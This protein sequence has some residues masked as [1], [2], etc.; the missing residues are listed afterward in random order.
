LA[1]SVAVLALCAGTSACAGAH[2]ATGAT[3]NRRIDGVR[4][5]GR[6]VSPHSY[7]WFTRAELHFVRGEYAAAVDAYRQA[8]VGPT[9]DSLVV[10]RLAVALDRDGRREEALDLLEEALGDNPESEA[11][12]MARA[13]IAVRHDQPDRAI[14]AFERAEKAAPLST[15]PPLGLA[16]FLRKRDATE[17]AVAVLERFERRAAREGVD[18][19]R[20]RLAL[21]IDRGDALAAA[22]AARSLL[23]IEPES[24]A[25][26]RRAAR[27]AFESG[28]AALA[29]RLVENLPRRSGDNPLLLQLLLRTGRVAAV[30]QLLAF[31]DAESFGGLVQT[32]RAWLAIGRP[33]PARELAAAA[34]S[35]EERPPALLVA[36]D[37]ESMMGRFEEAAR[38]Y[39][40]VPRGAT[41]FAG[42]RLGLARV[43]AASGL[44]RLAAEVLVDAALP[45]PVIARELAERRLAGGSL[46]GALSAFDAMDEPARTAGRAR[47]LERAGRTGEAARLYQRLAR[48][49]EGLQRPDA[50]RALA[51]QRAASGDLPAA[52]RILESL[53]ARAPGEYL[54]RIRLA[55][56]VAR[57]GDR[58]RAREQA[59]A[60]LPLV[61]ETALRERLRSIASQ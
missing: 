40:R 52:I 10:A 41:A 55:E 49:R 54:A 53:I 22:H 39:A 9:D 19:S 25:E 15:D 46:A 14:D 6:F 13:E 30:E 28:N 4:R 7:E 42:A 51:E 35:R 45:D 59:R 12:W 8:L 32:A 16:R 60:L 18:A 24:A 33:E 56:L 2:P 44:P 61:V 37:A 31:A 1:W 47:L 20:V 48:H 34:L 5:P 23:R 29:L 11:L 3:V 21:A 43:L 17:R 57:A 58:E 27:L 38:L 36:A 26:I 50:E